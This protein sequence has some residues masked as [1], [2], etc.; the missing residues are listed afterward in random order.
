MNILVLIIGVL[1]IVKSNRVA[2][3]M[4]GWGLGRKNIGFSGANTFLLTVQG[5]KHRK[6]DIIRSN[7][8]TVHKHGIVLKIFS[9]APESQ[10]N[11]V[12]LFKFISILNATSH[13]C[14]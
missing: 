13:I 10:G 4:M 1:F 2:Y 9:I 3:L 7:L 6:C 14:T 11:V 12:Y 8:L 5:V